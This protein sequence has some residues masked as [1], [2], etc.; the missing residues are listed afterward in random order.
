MPSYSI[1]NAPTEMAVCQLD[2]AEIGG[3]WGIWREASADGSSSLRLRID[4]HRTWHVQ[5]THPHVGDALVVL[6][7]K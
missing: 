6:G 5:P 7:V 2:P 4:V 3:D 1:S